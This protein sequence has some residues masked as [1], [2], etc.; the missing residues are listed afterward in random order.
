MKMCDMALR[1]AHNLGVIETTKTPDA[2]LRADITS[3]ERANGKVQDWQ[4]MYP[5]SDGH[6]GE[7]GHMV[8]PALL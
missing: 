5:Q 1:S 6:F 2:D 4:H 7:L 8:D 3:V